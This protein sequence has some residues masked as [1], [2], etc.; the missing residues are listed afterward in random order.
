MLSK[1]N[2]VSVVVPVY[3]V[4]KY[5]H[6]C[7]DSLLNQTCRPLEI[8][9]VDDGATDRS[10]LI[11]DEY[12]ARYDIIRVIH[13][14]NGGLSSARKAGWKAAKGEFICFVDS[15]DYVA[16]IYIEKLSDCLGVDNVDLCLCSWAKDC[17]GKISEVHL[18]YDK[19]F[20]E[21]AEI[22]EQYILPIVGT[23]SAPGAINI[24]GF[25][26]IRMYRTRKLMEDDFV[27]EREYFTEDVILNIS[28][29]QRLKGRIA[30]VAAPLYYYCINPGSLTIK[31]RKNG[32]KMRLACYRLCKILIANLNVDP[33]AVTERLDANMVSAVKYGIFNIGKIRNYSQFKIEL[34]E[35]FN[36]PEV[37]QI[38]CS[39]HWP[40]ITTW[41]RI[42]F[43]A[44]RYRLYFFLYKLLEIRKTLWFP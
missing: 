33:I 8:I 39:N 35:L 19:S 22:V 21:N 15:D 44:Y 34:K 24:P 12:A 9:L 32:F 2:N 29:A 4:E 7:I 27:S 38:F 14:E 20:I 40:M 30:I 26:P 36:T 25:V 16:D 1:G 43:V 28:Y 31:Y 41:Q 18:Q 6:R 11:C 3:N 17:A 37:R 10:G 5:L 13:K 42:F 23:L